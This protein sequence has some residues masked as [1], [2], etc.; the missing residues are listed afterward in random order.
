MGGEGLVVLTWDA[1]EDRL[2]DTGL[3]VR[4]RDDRPALVA[5]VRALIPEVA[6]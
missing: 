1:G 3:L 5:A 4:H 2:L 6:A